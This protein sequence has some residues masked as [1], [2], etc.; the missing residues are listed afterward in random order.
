MFGELRIRRDKSKAAGAT[1][2]TTRG[3]QPIMARKTFLDFFKR[4]R[5]FKKFKDDSAGTGQPGVLHRAAGFVRTPPVESASE[6]QDKSTDATADASAPRFLSAEDVHQLFSGAPHFSAAIVQGQG[7]ISV[8]HPWDFELQ[9]R[10]ASD[11]APIPHAAFYGATL[12]RHLPARG[13]GDIKALYPVTYDIGVVELPSMLASTGREP[14]T[15]GLEFFLQEPEADILNT[16]TETEDPGEV[17]ENFSNFELL[18][19]QPEKLGIRKFDLAT[20]AER[21]VELSTIYTATGEDERSFNILNHCSSAE[22]HASLFGKILTAPK[23]DHSTSDPK[24]LKVQIE[25]LVKI[26]NLKRVWYNFS[27]VEWRIRVGQLLFT[28]GVPDIAD[29]NISEPE[30]GLSERDVVLLQ[31]LLSCELYTR[32]EAIASLSVEEVK[33][34]LHLTSEDVQKFRRMESRKVR[35]DLVLARRFLENVNA[36]TYTRPKLVP[37]TEKSL[38]RSIFGISQRESTMKIDEVDIAFEPRRQDAQLSGLFYFAE[39]LKW[40]NREAVEAHFTGVLSCNTLDQLSTTPSI[41]ATP[42]STPGTLTPRSFRSNLE[43]GYFGGANSPEMTPRS[44][45]LQPPSRLDISDIHDTPTPTKPSIGGWLTRSYLTGLIMPGEAICHLLISSILENDAESIAVLGENANLYGGFV[46][47]GRSFWSKSCIVGRVIA[48]LQDTGECM[49]W[50]SSNLVP[51]GYGDGWLDVFSAPMA[52]KKFDIETDALAMN[53]D[54]LSGKETQ[55]VE[56]AELSLPQDGPYDAKSSAAI[57]FKG[58][59]LRH[60]SATRGFTDE[61]TLAASLGFTV[62]D[63]DEVH[64][65]PLANLVQFVSAYPCTPPKNVVVMKHVTQMDAN[66]TSLLE[67]APS[68]PLHMGYHY[69][70]L[71]A[72]ELLNPK[73]DIDEGDSD[74]VVII[75]ARSEDSVLEVLARAWCASEGVNALVARVGRTCLACAIREARGLGVRFVIRVGGR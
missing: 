57:R 61:P 67:V 47:K 64:D 38:A 45:Q 23:Y 71:H 42:L 33:R 3:K 5:R 10:E 31:L 6:D 16:H 28:D 22:L 27:I 53:T 55:E 74:A 9:T 30:D 24:G 72:M 40:P 21:L 14:G 44:F 25:A 50:I 68:H 32:L 34:S 11:S 52:L 75:D 73:L 63:E 15:V 48:C 58:L 66:D 70:M 41:Y 59:R 2:S 51:D 26:L 49:G 39:A 1:A 12:R 54:L 29:S 8:S 20:V 17:F 7:Q 4:A 35:W 37:A 69:R 62:L 13:S 65:I 18:E 46:Y 56:F 19:S 60:N 43:S 36:K